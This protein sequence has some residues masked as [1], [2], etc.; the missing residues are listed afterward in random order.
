MKEI[1]F[2]PNGVSSRGTKHRDIPL[3]GKTKQRSE[4]DKQKSV[5]EVL[6]LLGEF[7][8]VTT[9]WQRGYAQCMTPGAMQMMGE[10]RQ[11]AME[12]MAVLIETGNHFVPTQGLAL[13]DNKFFTPH[14]TLELCEDQA[15]LFASGASIAN[16]SSLD[17]SKS[18]TVS[19]WTIATFDGRPLGWCKMLSNRLNNHLPPWARLN[20]I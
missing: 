7:T 8:N 6:G 2:E 14:R 5:K 12:P 19:G 1:E 4:L 17:P 3:A 18:K 10:F 9:D 15:K 11:V 16:G 20:I 13:L